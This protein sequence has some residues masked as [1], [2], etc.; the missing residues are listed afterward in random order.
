MRILAWPAFDSRNRNPYNRLLYESLRAADD[1]MDVT[2][3]YSPIRALQSPQIWHLHWPERATHSRTFVGALVRVATFMV[4]VTGA[5]L[6]G[7]RIVWTV[8]NLRGHD[9]PFPRLE[10]LFLQWLARRVDGIN[11]LS[12]YGLHL[13]LQEY[14]VLRRRPHA[15]V[16]HGHFMGIYPD[17]I[18]RQL[19][20]ERLKVGLDDQVILYVG[21]VSRYKNVPTLVSRFIELPDPNLKLVVA[22]EP[23]TAA[24]ASEVDAAAAGDERVLFHLRHVGD[25]ELQVFLRAADLVVLPFAD[26]LN[27]SSVLL[28]LSFGRPVLVPGAGAMIE[29]EQT[30]G[31]FWVRTYEGSLQRADLERALQNTTIDPLSLQQLTE[32][33]RVRHDWAVAGSRTAQFYRELVAES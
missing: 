23:T 17:D 27:S 11:S 7:S 13:A 3:F 10:R 12:D 32:L 25:D 1:S 6:R 31:Q 4:L 5:K 22:G 19:A 24:L 29:H 8:H 28:A 14:P 9:P 30:F 26:V 20:R 21:R 33:L 18:P 16:P 15:V 2:D